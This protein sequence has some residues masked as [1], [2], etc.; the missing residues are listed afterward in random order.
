VLHFGPVGAGTAYK[1]A[2]N[3][4]GSVQIVRPRGLALAERAG[5]DPKLVVDAIA[6]SQAAS[7]Q[8]VRNTQHDRGD[9]SPTSCSRPCCASG[10]RLRAAP[11]ESLGVA[12]CS[13]PQPAKP[14]AP[15]RSRRSRRQA[16]IIEVARKATRE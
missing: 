14:R 6:T 8:V 12:T 15:R 9:F 1:L 16:R 5:L 3:L 7:P 10:R 4:I 11:A 13:A 2:I